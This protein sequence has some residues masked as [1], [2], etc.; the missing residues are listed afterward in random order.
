MG[1]AMFR[2]VKSAQ[3]RA[4]SW[5]RCADDYDDKWKAKCLA[6]AKLAYADA[7][8]WLR[9]CRPTSMEMRHE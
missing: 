4:R 7:R 8:L 2:H 6:E 5:R 3:E 1:T 9:F